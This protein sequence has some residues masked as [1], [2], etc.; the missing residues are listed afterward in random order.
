MLDGLPLSF[1][2]WPDG[3]WRGALR[4]STLFGFIVAL[5]P[6]ILSSP[7]CMVVELGLTKLTSLM[8]FFL[9][10]INQQVCS[11][12][13]ELAIDILFPIFLLAP[14]L[15]CHS[16]KHFLLQSY[17]FSANRRSFCT[18]PTNPRMF[19]PPAN[20]IVDFALFSSQ[21]KHSWTHSHIDGPPPTHSAFKLS[22]PSALT[23]RLKRPVGD[24]DISFRLSWQRSA[25][26]SGFS[27][28][29]S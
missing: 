18:A 20:E 9:S 23:G 27:R 6:P 22:I 10:F 12:I 21:V 5:G 11:F 2:V 4:V 24:Q 17:S 13:L 28:P 15:Y 29:L 25:S 16:S 3:C 8:S 26:Q 14:S 1:N 19:V 7:P